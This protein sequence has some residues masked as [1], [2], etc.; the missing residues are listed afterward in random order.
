MS[1]AIKKILIFALVIGGLAVLAI[2]FFGGSN[3]DPN[4][5]STLTTTT[6]TPTSGQSQKFLQSLSQIKSMNLDTTLLND[7]AYLNLKDFTRPIVLEDQRLVGR[8]NPFAPIGVDTL[9]NEPNSSIIQDTQ[10]STQDSLQ[11]PV[12]ATMP[13]VPTGNSTGSQTAPR[14]TTNNNR[15]R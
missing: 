11:N 6:Q 2:T 10:N 8:P 14:N 12:E 3:A 4:L 1:P 7:P 13:T 15:Q 5:N 9:F